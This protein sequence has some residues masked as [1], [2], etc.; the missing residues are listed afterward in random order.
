MARL[1]VDG[2][3]VRLE[4]GSSLG[5][6]RA[7]VTT[8]PENE[9]QVNQMKPTDTRATRSYSKWMW[10]QFHLSFT[11]SR[12]SWKLYIC[13]HRHKARAQQLTAAGKIGFPPIRM[14]VHFI[15]T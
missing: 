8:I 1:C 5:G 9:V 13:C 3:W 2:V 7:L 6:V 10:L 4:L 11:D 12:D 15:Y 14:C